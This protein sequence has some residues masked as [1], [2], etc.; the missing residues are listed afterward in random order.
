MHCK[1]N[2]FSQTDI[3]FLLSDLREAFNI[4]DNAGEGFITPRKLGDVMKALGWNPTEAE[5]QD[6]IAAVDKDGKK[7]STFK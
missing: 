5:V 2:L 7:L 4:F 1:L 3:I 6:L